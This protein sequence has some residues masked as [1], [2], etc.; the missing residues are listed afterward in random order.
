MDDERL[1]D[2]DLNE[3]TRTRDEVALVEDGGEVAGA[4]RDDGEGRERNVLVGF[5]GCELGWTEEGQTREC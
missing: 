5:T 4:V 2:R 3:V 1:L